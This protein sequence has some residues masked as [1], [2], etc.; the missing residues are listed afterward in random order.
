LI[1]CYNTNTNLRQYD[2]T[3]TS[4]KLVVG[5]VATRLFFVVGGIAVVRVVVDVSYASPQGHEIVNA[6]LHR[7]YSPGIIFIFF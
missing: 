5:E 6:A 7:E 1:R 4:T 2:L 3:N